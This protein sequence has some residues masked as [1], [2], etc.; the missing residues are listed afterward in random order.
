MVQQTTHFLAHL[1]KHACT[2][3]CI[4]RQILGALHF[5]LAFHLKT[6]PWGIVKIAH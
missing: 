1:H 3:M 6:D 2:S 4:P 5:S